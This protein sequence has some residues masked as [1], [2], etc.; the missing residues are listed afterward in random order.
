V[1][2]KVMASQRF[3]IRRN[4]PVTAGL[5][6]TSRWR[7]GRMRGFAVT[8]TSAKA[9]ASEG[10]GLL[11]KPT[12]NNVASGWSTSL[13]IRPVASLTSWATASTALLRHDGLAATLEHDALEQA[14][15]AAIYVVA[16][17][18]TAV[19]AL[20]RW[21]ES[22]STI[23]WNITRSFFVASPKRVLLFAKV[24]EHHFGELR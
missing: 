18:D 20:V 7:R 11:Y 21:K 14:E 22:G 17:K 10:A 1:I 15:H 23:V 2:S 13:P 6:K 4:W 9:L 3:P 12:G 8:S 24:G 16:S 19:I 5:L